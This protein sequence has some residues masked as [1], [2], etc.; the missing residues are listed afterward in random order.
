MTP[1]EIRKIMLETIEAEG[2]GYINVAA[3]FA[4]QA[5]K[6]S[7]MFGEDI[8]MQELANNPKVG[9]THPT[10]P[11]RMFSLI[12]AYQEKYGDKV[13]EKLKAAED[14]KFNKEVERRMQEARS[15]E[16]PA[17]PFPLRVEPSVLDTLSADRKPADYTVDS[18][19]AEYERLQ[20]ARQGS[21]A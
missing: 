2:R 1:D 6:H 16:G 19:V 3:W 14:E 7:R 13:A 8:D 21:G 17:H 9:K 12:D 4:S 18:A 10:D 5:V 11:Q 20:Q 15:K